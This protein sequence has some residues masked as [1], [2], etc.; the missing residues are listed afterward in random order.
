MPLRLVKRTGAGGDKR[1]L[2]QGFALSRQRKI[3]CRTEHL[4]WQG[5]RW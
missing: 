4:R 5:L 3:S 2:G 1:D